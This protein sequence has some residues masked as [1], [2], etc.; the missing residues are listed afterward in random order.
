MS[1]RSMK[2]RT[3]YPNTRSATFAGGSWV[4]FALALFVIVS[5]CVAPVATE[6]VAEGASAAV[7]VRPKAT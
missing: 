5:A 7:T 4:P 1:G 3:A 2:H 6:N